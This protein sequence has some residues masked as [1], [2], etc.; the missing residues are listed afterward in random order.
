[1]KVP[2][3]LV[4]IGFAVTI[5]AAHA[6]PE[7]AARAERSTFA[8]GSEIVFDVESGQATRAMPPDQAGLHDDARDGH[9]IAD[10]PRTAIDRS[11]EP[12][13]LPLVP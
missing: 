2:S 5:S 3:M 6:A 7:A 1:M 11:P 12:D 9:S 10:A 4:A 13:F 8:P